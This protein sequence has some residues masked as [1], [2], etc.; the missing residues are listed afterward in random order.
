ML[1]WDQRHL[2]RT[3]RVLQARTTLDNPRPGCGH[4][5]SGGPVCRFASDAQLAAYAGAA[6]LEASSAGK[7]RHRLNRGGNRRLNAILYRIVLTQSRHAEEAQAYLQQ[8]LS[9]GKTPREGRRSLKRYIVT[10]GMAGLA[11]AG[12]WRG[13]PARLERLGFEP[14]VQARQRLAL[15]PAA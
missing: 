12:P 3:Q 1:A 4:D 10:I 5:R 2:G 14:P 15:Q 6:P 9:E 13:R 7:A 11:L 8:K